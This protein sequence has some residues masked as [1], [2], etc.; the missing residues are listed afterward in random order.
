MGIGVKNRGGGV[1]SRVMSSILALAVLGALGML[2]YVVATPIEERFTE[3]YLLGLTGKAGDYPSELMMGE[4]GKIV[5]SII[6][7]EQ[8]TANY[9]VEVRIDGVTNSEVGPVTL[10]HDKEWEEIVGF[11]PD[12][13]G[14][15]QTVEFLLYRQ[16]QSEVY[17]RL[18]LWVD[19]Q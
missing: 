12:R 18:H 10:E 3:F 16:G 4:E 15:N 7:R 13:V 1:W 8:E 5:V 14:D 11:T 2:G 17:Q 9:R 19:V 6:N